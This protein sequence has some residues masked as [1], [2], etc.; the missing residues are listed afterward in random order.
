MRS[1]PATSLAAFQVQPIPKSLDFNALAKSFGELR[2]VSAMESLGLSEI[3]YLGENQ[4]V[5]IKKVQLDSVTAES[6]FRTS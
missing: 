4:K 6:K 3:G 1:I 5:R 2:P